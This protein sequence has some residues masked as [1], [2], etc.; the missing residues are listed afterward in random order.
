MSADLLHE[1]LDNL[2]FLAR[3]SVVPWISAVAFAL[4]GLWFGRALWGDWARQIRPL[5]SEQGELKRR[6]EGLAASGSSPKQPAPEPAPPLA[7]AAADGAI[8]ASPPPPAGPGP[9]F[10][11]IPVHPPEATVIMG[12]VVP[13][14]LHEAAQR[15]GI[16]VA[17]ATTT[18]AA[19]ASAVPAPAPAKPEPAVPAPAPAQPEPAVP[20]PAPAKPKV[21]TPPFPPPSSATS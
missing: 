14:K 17:A 6:L 16:P 9:D 10:C 12:E 1:T 5:R 11:P 20:A 19:A 21:G 7:G 3:H 8:A 4:L 18:A 15:V 13:D 2:L